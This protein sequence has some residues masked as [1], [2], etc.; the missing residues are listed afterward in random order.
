MKN[1]EIT[2]LHKDLIFVPA[3]RQTTSARGE[4]IHLATPDFV[5]EKDSAPSLDWNE[6]GLSFGIICGDNDFYD[7]E[8]GDVNPRKDLHKQGNTIAL[9]FQPNGG[10]NFYRFEFSARGMQTVHYY[11]KLKNGKYKPR[12]ISFPWKAKQDRLVAGDI[13]SVSFDISWEAIKISRENFYGSRFLVVRYKCKP[14]SPAPIVTNSMRLPANQLLTPDKWNVIMPPDTPVVPL[15][16]AVISPNQMLNEV[17]KEYSQEMLSRDD[18]QETLAQYYCELLNKI[19]AAYDCSEYDET[20][21]Q[22]ERFNNLSEF[23][24]ASQKMKRLVRDLWEIYET[25]KFCFIDA[26]HLVME[27]ATLLANKKLREQKVK[28]NKQEHKRLEASKSPSK[29]KALSFGN[30]LIPCFTEIFAKERKGIRFGKLGSQRYFYDHCPR[31]W[32]I[33]FPTFRKKYSAWLEARQPDKVVNVPGWEC[34]YQKRC[35]N[36]KPEL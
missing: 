35:R 21:R 31:S 5:E 18:S 15:P 11:S 12:K 2:I 16:D 25:K 27:G 14:S 29:E 30:D 19:Y 4:I 36:F 32:K 26:I 34:P 1:Q 28:Q 7:Y 23:W 9:Y 17:K 13:W 8:V 24:G 20:F 3:M 33:K 22:L 6:T 10:K